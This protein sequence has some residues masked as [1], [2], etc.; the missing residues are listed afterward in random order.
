MY[1]ALYEADGTI[2]GVMALAHE[3]TDQV[4][5]RKK[6]EVSEKKFR[7]LTNAMPQKI[8]NADADGNILFFNQQWIDD[9]GLTFEELKDWGWEK[10]MHPDDLEPTVK[11][12][13]HSVSTGDVFDME[14][15][16]QNKEGGYRW[17]LSRAVPIRD[18]N[19]KIIM[20]VGSN[21][22][23]HAQKEQKKN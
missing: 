10:S 11:N 19:G 17:H 20:W 2:S 12:W 1:E 5:A 9:T 16:I 8:T 7:L 21:T 4:N 15:R 3:I 18:E 22:D 13:K 14:C 6:I 23:I